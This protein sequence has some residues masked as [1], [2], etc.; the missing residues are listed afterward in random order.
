MK[1]KM[2]WRKLALALALAVSCMPQ[3]MK[4]QEVVEQMKALPFEITNI[5]VS[6]NT[7]K[8]KEAVT[9]TIDVQSEKPMSSRITIHLTAPITKKE[10]GVT[11]KYDGNGRYTGIFQT[12]EDEEDG[13]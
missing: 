2:K 6:S 3:S 7:V 11:M 12:S 4:A 1:K 5:G 13:I 9:Y 10:K 8:A